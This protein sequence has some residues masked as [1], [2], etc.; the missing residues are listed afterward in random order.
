M[1]GL[2]ALQLAASHPEVIAL[3]LYAPALRLRWSRR[4]LIALRFAAPFV[5]AVAKPGFVEDELWQ[6]YRVYPLRGVTQLLQ[7]Q[8]AVEIALPAV[9]QPILIF[10]GELDPSVD[11]AV[12][13]LIAQGAKSE[14]TEIH[15]MPHS[16]H[17][18]ILDRERG[19]VAA[20]TV[21]FVAR[22]VKTLAVR[23]DAARAPSHCQ[24][25]PDGLA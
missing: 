16:G 6:G 23:D 1:G 20:E 13:D 17:C 10:H 4:K 8:Q 25:Q 12:P 14:E 3:L 22:Q 24:A 9:R 15:R 19:R 2:L 18:V 7:L 5:P 11:A 21:A